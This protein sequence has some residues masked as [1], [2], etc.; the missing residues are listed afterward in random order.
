MNLSHAE[1]AVLF[2]PARAGS[3]PRWRTIGELLRDAAGRYDDWEFL[4]FPEGSLSFAEADAYV[5]RLARVLRAHGVGRGDRVALMMGNV[6]EWPL[7][8]LAVTRAGAVA[9]P[10]NARCGPADLAYVLK[11]S[12][13]V[14]ALASQECVALVRKVAGDVDSLREV[15]AL[16]DLAEELADSSPLDPEIPV[17]PSDIANFQYTS[18]TTG[19]PKACMLSQDYWLRTAWLMA[20]G[21]ELH[22][23]DVV[24]TAQAFSYMD[25]QWNA[26]MCLMGGV[27][28][29]VLPR[30]S[31]S[32]F[33]DSVREHGA[34]LT[35]VLGTMPLLMFKQ[36]RSAGD[37]DH[38]MRLVL[39]SGIAPARH[40]AFEER[41]GAPWREVYGSTESGLDL[42]VAPGAVETVGSGAMGHPP[43]GKDVLVVDR[44]GAVLPVGETGEIVV[45]G[46]PMMDGYWNHP[47]TT[48]QAFRG[49]WYHTGDL[50]HR[51]VAGRVH[52]AG[53]LKDMIRR[54]GENI[55]C[56]EVES[57]LE[58]HAAVLAAAVVAIPDE[59]FEELPKA[60][61]QLRPGHSPGTDVARSVLGHARRL[62]ARFKVPAYLEFVDSFPLTPSARIQKR[63]LVEP[64]R[65][66]RAGSFDAARD[67][68]A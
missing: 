12:G 27:P 14:L 25:P 19:F 43:K 10:V 56:A 60:F 28:L 40:R 8:W 29:V 35:Y 5:S 33:W 23:D 17:A 11:D 55:S 45:R 59:L 9:V 37:R 18:G 2:D 26:V 65:D 68:W 15:H 47:E 63:R 32:G 50:G 53:R 61:V 58:G 42:I 64:E 52:H 44:R 16:D 38:S 57:V 66:Q 67:A 24:L 34:T 39:C 30:F 1:G 22:A 20:V 48:A 21:A 36:P 54:G 51:D 3:R 62:L 6:P 13:S 7:S 49:G 4:R 46:E 41:W 31:A